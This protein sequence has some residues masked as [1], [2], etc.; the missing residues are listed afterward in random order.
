MRALV[1][2]SFR[3][4]L[5]LCEVADPSCPD[6]GV[7]VAVEAC[8]VCRSDHHAWVGSDPD[9]AL[10]HVMGHEF[11]GRVIA[12]GTGVKAFAVGDRVTAPFVLGCGTC[13][14]CRRDQPTV[15]NHQAV[16]GFTGWGAFAQRMAIPFA[17]FNLVRL[18]DSLDFATA[19]GMGCRVTTA[20]RAL[21]DRGR[22]AAG[23]WVSVHGCGGVGLSAIMIAAALGAQ[24]LAVDVRPQALEMAK[25]LGANICLDARDYPDAI[26]LGEAIRAATGGG[27]DL[28][29]DALGITATFHAALYGLRK[30]GRQVQ[31][32]MPVGAH[33]A[34]PIPLLDLIYSRQLSLHGTR[35]MG[36]S[37]FGALFA[38]LEAGRL[39]PS[40]L[41]SKTIAL[42]EVEAAL[43]AMDSPEAQVQAGVTVVTRF[44]A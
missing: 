1:M 20:F 15:C 41:V 7:V 34:P 43:R 14:D 38:M 26:A 3:G 31:I 17:D 22:V 30:L 32:G 33:V 19:A 28:A 42:S 37:R 18:P 4:P 2:N 35:G 13:E 29:L 24:V 40:K 9:A 5:D 39:D 25:A 6:G 23:E 11:A 16:M 36:A 8:G 10:P 44:D 27:S 12:V 21:V